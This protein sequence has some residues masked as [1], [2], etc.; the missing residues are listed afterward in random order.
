MLP[1]LTIDVPAIEHNARLV[2]RLLE[3]YGVRLV[4]VT[5]ACLGD[6]RIAAAMLSGGAG[7]LADSRLEN[8]ARLREHHPSVELQLLRPCLDDGISQCDDSSRNHTDYRGQAPPAE[9]DLCFVSSFQQVRLILESPSALT[10]RFMLMVEAGDGRE[11]VPPGLFSEQARR[12]A[13]LPGAELAGAAA[14]IA[15]AR[16]EAP[17]SAAL[18]GLL[19]AAGTLGIRKPLLSAGGSGLLRLI[20][21]ENVSNGGYSASMISTLDE[22]RCGES[23]LLGS[24]PGAASGGCDEAVFLEGAR[25]DAFRLEATVLEAYEKDGGLQVLLGLGSQDIG[26]AVPGAL[27]PHYDG[28]HVITATSDYLS[29]AID[30]ADGGRSAPAVGDTLSLI[31]GYSALVAA[32]TSPYVEKVYI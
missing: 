1:R 6:P 2:A 17:L 13:A 20:I 24:I 28:A 23:L 22:L 29:L 32:M 3:S 9:A 4:G 12:I 19:E 7:A 15:C 31:P 8:I 11:G 5:K 26:G 30:S 16:P 25:R 10:A 14:T 27:K 18:A 21:P